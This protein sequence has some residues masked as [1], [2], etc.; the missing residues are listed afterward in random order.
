MFVI[1][2]FSRS[3]LT[4]LNRI[5]GF[6]NDT[7]PE[8][9]DAAAERLRWGFSSVK[10]YPT[11]GYLMDRLKD[12]RELLVPFGKGNY[13]IRYRVTKRSVVVLHI[14]HNREKR[15]DGSCL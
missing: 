11:I 14:W 12:F 2:R 6:M 13:I 9:L 4:D 8:T 5:Y 10:K 3:A 15:N 1:L 7:A